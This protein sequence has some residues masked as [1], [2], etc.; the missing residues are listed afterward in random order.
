MPLMTTAVGPVGANIPSVTETVVVSIPGITLPR[1]GMPVAISYVGTVLTGTL[2][3][4]VTI[5]CRRGVD[6]TG[7]LVGQA[8]VP[9]EA[10]STTEPM[11]GQWIDQPG[12][13]ANGTYVITVQQTGGGTAGTSQTAVATAL[14]G[15]PN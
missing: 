6:A 4:A 1:P 2:V 5:R 10:A 8:E 7:V 15:T 9:A 13:L 12:E 14:V 3:T 11:A